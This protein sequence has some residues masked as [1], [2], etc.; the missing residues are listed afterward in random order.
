M[1]D[2]FVIESVTGPS[3]APWAPQS[4]SSARAI[5]TSWYVLDRAF[6]YEVV[7]DF[8]AASHGSAQTNAHRRRRAEELCAHLNAWDLR[9]GLV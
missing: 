4:S 8:T 7:G 5:V 3:I 1:S 2:R 6:R 9:G